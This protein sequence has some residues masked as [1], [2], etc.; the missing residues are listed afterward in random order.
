MGHVN[1]LLQIVIIWNCL[2]VINGFFEVINV[3]ESTPIGA[4][5]DQLQPI[6]ENFEYNLFQA[7][8]PDGLA[9]FSV[10]KK[11]EVTLK[12][13]LNYEID[14]VNYHTVTVIK[15]EK[16]KKYGGTAFTRQIKIV[17]SN[18]HSPRF[19]KKIYHG[20]I[21]EGLPP[22]SIA[23]G[24]EDCYATDLDSSGIN[25]YSI[26]AGN[27]NNEFMLD[28]QELKGVRLLVVKTTKVLDRDEIRSTPYLDLEVQANDGGV[29]DE[30]KFSK[31]VI[32]IKIEDINDNPPVFI[33]NY[34]RRSIQEN[35]AVMSPVMKISASD[36]DEGQN[37]EVYYHFESLVENFYIH[38]STG[39]ISVAYPLDA[40][41]KIM[42]DL[43]VISQDKSVLEPKSAKAFVS[44]QI[45]DIPDYP[46][47]YISGEPM[48]KQNA[49][50]VTIRADLP[51]MSF[52]FLA[53]L[54]NPQKHIRNTIKYV[55]TGQNSHYFHIS[56][57]TGVVTL[58]QAL[59]HLVTKKITYMLYISVGNN[60]KSSDTSVLNI[61]VQPLDLNMHQPVFSQSTLSIEIFESINENTEIGYTVSA[62]DKDDGND[63]K[64][65]YE[66]AGGS[67]IG[68]FHVDKV[69]G[70]LTTGVKFKG[71]GVYDL[72]IRAIDGGLYKRYSEMYVRIKI[73]YGLDTPPV[74][75]NAMYNFYIPE[76][77]EQDSFIGIVYARSLVPG[78]TITYLIAE[79][80]N[81]HGIAVDGH[82]GVITTTQPLDYEQEKT[83]FLEIIIQ[84]RGSGVVY[85]TAL[86]VNILNE[87]DNPPVFTR[88]SVTV[89]VAENSGMLSSLVC[90][91][92][93]DE[94]GIDNFPLAYSIEK[95]NIDNTFTI[96]S[97]TGIFNYLLH[98]IFMLKVDI[99]KT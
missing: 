14:K 2:Q 96:N 29:G 88:P 62:V 78:K 86:L 58:K 25:D 15:Q 55:M 68:Y 33:Y 47:A 46:I 87:N 19:T 7:G 38:P 36:N 64:V 20:S 63:G 22:G 98:F 59:N 24:L 93:T 83:V 50:T 18:N 28:V 34:W 61:N 71:T 99:Q 84:V 6:S 23:K 31:T 66:I 11:G 43:T 72:Y 70:V 8:D 39:I 73:L 51:V 3:G 48:M 89:H 21:A 74:I 40:N 42:Y 95:G 32:R 60:K 45:I 82:T 10:N 80:E 79:G 44:L 17:D 76:N 77:A 97:T 75:S 56:Q 12:R 90:L 81:M 26:T 69:T 53:T 57:K 52:V 5:I 67:G 35:S 27:N 1:S 54:K 65:T 13:Q 94:D 49:F 9:L 41:E 91:F 85:K 16:G 37:A 4:V 30:Q 92:A